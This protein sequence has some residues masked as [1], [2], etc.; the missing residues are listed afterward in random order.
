MAHSFLLLWPVPLD[1][2]WTWCPLAHTCTYWWCVHMIAGILLKYFIGH[3]MLGLFYTNWTA[4]RR[5]LDSEKAI[6]VYFTP[7]QELSLA[8]TL[9]INQYNVATYGACFESSSLLWF[10]TKAL[11]SVKTL[12]VNSACHYR[13]LESSAALLW[14]ILQDV[15]ILFCVVMWNYIFSM[16]FFQNITKHTICCIFILRHLILV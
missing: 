12:V 10:K 13:R 8:I 11:L 4:A 6:A 5:K 9:Y 16:Q 7:I 3:H 2:W 14:E 15:L 1:M